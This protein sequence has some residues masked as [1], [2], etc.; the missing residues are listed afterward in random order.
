[1]IVRRLREGEE[2]A[3]GGRY[4][5]DECRGTCGLERNRGVYYPYNRAVHQA[6]TGLREGGA[7]EGKDSAVSPSEEVTRS[8]F[9]RSQPS[10][11]V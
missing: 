1:M 8:G 11:S 3:R 9:S 4:L 7:T 6:H 2:I 10:T 5:W